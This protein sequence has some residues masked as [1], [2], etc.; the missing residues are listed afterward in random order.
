MAKNTGKNTD[1]RLENLNFWK[2][3]DP[4][5][6]PTGHPKGQ[7]NYATIYREALI[8]LAELNETT[9]DSLENEILS[10]GITLARKGDYRFYKDLLDRLHG[11]AEQPV[12]FSDERTNEEDRQIVEEL[13]EKLKKNL[14]KRS[15]EKAKQDGEL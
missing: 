13:R 4:S 11:Q 7:R 14:K 10:K 2:K 12:K 8:K 3:G 6:N 15:Q 1:K 9:P 5:P